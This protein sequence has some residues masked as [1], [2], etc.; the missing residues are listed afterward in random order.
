M[1]SREPD[2]CPGALQLHQ[3]ADGPLARIR[4][5]GGILTPTQLE[6]LATAAE[7]IG[8]G[9]LELTSRG[10]LQ[11]R[12]VRDANALQSELEQ[13]GLL[14]SL[15]HERVRNLVASPLSGRVGGLGDI[16]AFVG[17]LDEK[18]QTAP[19]LADLPGR[20]LFG[21]DDGRG[22]ISALAPDFGIQ[23]TGNDDFAVILGGVDSGARTSNPVDVLI[24]AA[25]AFLDIR[26][27]EWRLADVPG[28]TNR[29]L[30]TI[31]LRRTEEPPAVSPPTTPIGWLEQADGRVTLAGGLRFGTLTSQLARFVA[32]VEVPIAITPWRSLAIFDL[33]EDVADTVLR[34]LAP[35]GLIFDASS[36]WLQITACAGKPGCAKAISDVRADATEAV[37][38][39]TLPGE[40]PQ[41]WSGCDRRCGKPK[42]V[43]DVVATTEGYRANYR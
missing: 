32:A 37:L 24:E 34:V 30:E 16:R 5:P 26:D 10:N 18:L 22:D 13:A 11:L 40:G 7:S 36:P 21:L 8:N 38:T 25:H 23:A 43:L 4:I 15:T 27:D 12:S 33:D 9:E 41:H 19:K 29:V 20:V 35:L 2:A 42:G 31:G 6:T 17:D 14:P 3:A 39:S 1:V 28:G